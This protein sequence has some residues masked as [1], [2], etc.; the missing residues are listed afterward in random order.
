M[1]SD[2]ER[3]LAML[4]DRFDTPAVVAGFSLGADDRGASRR[5]LWIL[6]A[7]LVA[8][9][10]DIDGAAAGT[11][12]KASVPA[13]AQA[14]QNRR[15]V[16]QLKKDRAR[17]P[18]H[19]RRVLD[20]GAVGGQFRRFCIGQTYNSMA[21]GLLVS[22]LRSPDYWSAHA[23]R[24]IRGNTATQTALL[25]EL[26]ALDL[27]N[28]LPSLNCPIVMVQGLDDQVASASAAER[29]AELLTAPSKQFARFEHS[30][31][32]PQLDQPERFRELRLAKVPPR[33][34]SLCYWFLPHEECAVTTTPQISL[35]DGGQAASDVLLLGAAGNSGRIAAELAARG[36]S[37]RLAG[38]RRGP[39]EDLARALAAE[40][41]TTD[42][43][44][45]DVSDGRRW[46]GDRL[47][48][49]GPLYGRAVAQAGP[50]IDACL[51]ADRPM[52][53]SR[54]MAG[55]TGLLDRDEEARAHGVT[56]VTGAGFGRPATETLVLRLVE[57][58]GGVPDRVRV[59]AVAEV[60]RQATACARRSRSP[61]PTGCHHLP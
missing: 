34:P 33:L 41:A 15:A 48:R 11:L 53:T 57:Q 18:P 35:A 13:T 60:T 3:L 49:R 2:T 30:A 25:P 28:T 29:Y 54:R 37:V 61:C 46:P 17:T 19:A 31:H 56:L 50:V 55:G 8:V 14:R 16:R 4:C 42:V 5:V 1:V 27:T 40:G 10:M 12:S 22:L 43:R 24:A 45:V 47:R 44:T 9:S 32:M 52:W 20:P 51:A 26:E 36:L 39:L 59:A 58:M 23:V 21:R 38:R 6:V 7:T